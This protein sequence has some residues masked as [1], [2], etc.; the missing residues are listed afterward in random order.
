[1]ELVRLYYNSI[2]VKPKVLIH[3][4]L[5]Y[6]GLYIEESAGD[7]ESYP[8][9]SVADIYYIGSRSE[10]ESKVL[11]FAGSSKAILI[12]KD[13]IM[14]EQEKADNYIIYREDEQDSCFFNELI[15]H[16]CGVLSYQNEENG[17]LL[18]YN[19]R[20]EEALKCVSKAYVNNNIM[21]S[22]LY[23]RCFY[24]QEELYRRALKHYT[25]F[26][27]QM[28]KLQVEEDN[29]DMMKYI[30]SYSKFEVNLICK[31]NSYEFLY[32]VE[33]LLAVC[34]EL[35]K[36]YSSNEQIHILTAD[37]KLELE[38]RWLEASEEY[39]SA[40]LAHCAY[41]YYKWGRIVRKYLKD[42]ESALPILKKAVELKP[43]YFAAWYQIGMCL[44]KKSDYFGAI[45][46]FQKI[47]GILERKYKNHL[48][49]PVELEYLFKALMKMAQIYKTELGNYVTAYAY[50]DLAESVKVEAGDT[51]YL[52]HV[53]GEA[54][55]DPDIVKIIRDKIE[56][57]LDVQLCQ[58]Y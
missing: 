36:K 25:A 54:L 44:E 58:M 26:V 46:A 50:S 39:A 3:H 41:A 35:A 57:K 32:P 7:N 2:E 31:N 45:K 47:G 20:L 43:D 24:K 55:K 12:F 27:E 37:I 16:L 56:Q 40:Q 13:G 33:D 23:T 4:F 14:S 52:S 5:R 11:S 9:S 17:S 1:M 42:Y 28:S 51:T 38:E 49:A 22:T 21:Q 19:H 53:W 29:M 15:K 8:I 34:Q 48:L 18:R 10:Y 30:I 6:L